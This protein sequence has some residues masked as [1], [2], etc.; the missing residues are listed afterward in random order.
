MKAILYTPAAKRQVPGV[1]SS[2]TLFLVQL[3]ETVLDC[4]TYD[5]KLVS[6]A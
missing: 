5:M 6:G 2:F 4:I 3:A 1:E